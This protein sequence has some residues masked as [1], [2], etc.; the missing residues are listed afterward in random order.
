VLRTHQAYRLPLALCAAAVSLCFCR[1]AAAETLVSPRW[2]VWVVDET[3][4]PVAGLNV[5]EVR[6]DLSCESVDHSETMFTD[7]HGHVQFH[8]RYMKWN[9]VKC[10]VYTTGDIV[11]F[12]K[13]GHGRHASITA[14]EAEGVLFGKNVDSSGHVIEW[15][16]S[17]EHLTSHI[18][19]RHQRPQSSSTTVRPASAPSTPPAAPPAASSTPPAPPSHP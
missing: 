1:P 16:G 14:G 3:G 5:T 8:A 17:P 9:P 6:E 4:R 12:G 13:R 18:I 15:H 7:R 11:T 2:D 19:V 10:G